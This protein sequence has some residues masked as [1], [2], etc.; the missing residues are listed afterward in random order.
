[1]FCEE[2]SLGRMTLE[3]NIRKLEL[4]VAL[5]AALGAVMANAPQAMADLLFTSP[6]TPTPVPAPSPTPTPLLPPVV[7]APAAPP[8]AATADL[9]TTLFWIGVGMVGTGSFLT[10]L[11]LIRRRRGTT[12]FTE[13]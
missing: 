10:L 12:D 8:P 13:R 11:T 5:L 4:L 6:L 9:G 3:D 1:V 2:A 7:L